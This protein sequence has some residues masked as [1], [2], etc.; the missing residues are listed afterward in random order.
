M[1]TRDSYDKWVAKL[2]ANET[3]SANELYKGNDDNDQA[4]TPFDQ[5]SWECLVFLE[6]CTR[7]QEPW[8]GLGFATE[9][10][11]QIKAALFRRAEK[12]DREKKTTFH[13]DLAKH[14]TDSR[15]GKA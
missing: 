13:H 4:N 11:A 15:K 8:I 5:L 10:H 14:A 2:A 9:V 7:D 12:L 3:I 1:M 6:Q